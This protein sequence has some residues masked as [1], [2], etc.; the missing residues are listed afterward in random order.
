MSKCVLRLR[1]TRSV[2]MLAEAAAFRKKLISPA[3]GGFDR[4]RYR[5]P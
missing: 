2:D 1:M 4:R 3:V 5:S